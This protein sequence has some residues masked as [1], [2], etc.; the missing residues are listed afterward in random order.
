[1]SP[2]SIGYKG[3]GRPNSERPVGTANYKCSGNV[4]GAIHFF[5][6][7]ASNKEKK[8]QVCPMCGDPNFFR[9]PESRK[10]I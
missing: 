8:C 7:P 4:N 1:M 5:G 9:L 10:R 2:N 3:V 6:R